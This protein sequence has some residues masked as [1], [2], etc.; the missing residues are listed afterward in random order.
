MGASE[1]LR[2]AIWGDFD[3]PFLGLPHNLY[4]V[5]TQ[6]W[7]S[8]HDYLTSTIDLICPSLIVEIG[9][10]KG[11]SVITMARKLASE[12]RD[13]A[14]LAV[15]TWL[16]SWQHWEQ[17]ERLRD[18]RFL[19]GYPHLYYTFLSNIINQNLQDF[20]V[21]LPADSSSAFHIITRKKIAPDMVHI[22]A[23]HDY[24]SV[25]GDL[26]KWYTALSPGGFIVCDDYD[27]SGRVWPSVARA[28]DDFLSRTPHGDFQ[29][30]PYKCRF[31]KP[32]EIKTAPASAIDG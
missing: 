26:A 1:Q 12:G 27:P 30:S 13:S 20:V 21:P 15:D 8:G 2:K 28:V 10:W 31:S 4:A 24:E 29:Y 5:D 17:P 23:G 32:T 6:G 7:N 25:M 9:V 14:I 19:H 16:G 22:D 11:G 18:L 3:S